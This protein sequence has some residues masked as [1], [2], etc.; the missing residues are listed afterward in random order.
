VRQD[1]ET[2]RETLRSLCKQT[3][4][5]MPRLCI[6]IASGNENSITLEVANEA[7]QF[8]F[9]RFRDLG[10]HAVNAVRRAASQLEQLN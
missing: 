1:F 7:E 8:S 10:Q 6:E 3:C 5:D 4:E 2:M 9:E